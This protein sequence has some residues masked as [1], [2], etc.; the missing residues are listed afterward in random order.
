MSF[1]ETYSKGLKLTTAIFSSLIAVGG[2]YYKV[3]GM[4]DEMV[5]DVISYQS[6]QRAADLRKDIMIV[7][8][9]IS[10]LSDNDLE[11]P[12]S[13]KFELR[14]LEEKLNDSINWK[15]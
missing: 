12:R 13:K 7:E 1:L 9:E 15:R 3:D 11:V 5:S 4:H 6:A 2:V 10:E 14:V 8:E